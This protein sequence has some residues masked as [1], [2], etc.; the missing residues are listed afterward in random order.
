MAEMSVPFSDHS[1]HFLSLPDSRDTTLIE[2]AIPSASSFSPHM[3]VN[4]VSR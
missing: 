2:T 3:M 4:Y 1:L